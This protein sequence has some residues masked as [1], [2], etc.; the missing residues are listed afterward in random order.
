[1]KTYD[2][3]KNDIRDVIA[4]NHHKI[5]ALGVKKLGLFG[6]FVRQE[7]TAQSDI[8]ILAEFE[9]DRKN[10][11]SFMQLSFLLEDMFERR[12]ELVTPEALSCHIRPYILSEVEYADIPS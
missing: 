4:R 1:M 11:D 3:A 10:F 9:P 7:Q 8:D 6:S 5:K 12:V 2:L